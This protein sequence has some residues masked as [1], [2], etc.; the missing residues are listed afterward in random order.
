MSNLHHSQSSRP[1]PRLGRA[2]EVEHMEIAIPA[3]ALLE[4]QAQQHTHPRARIAAPQNIQYHYRL[5]LEVAIMTL[6]RGSST[7]PPATSSASCRTSNDGKAACRLSR[8]FTTLLERSFGRTCLL[9]TRACQTRWRTW[10]ELRTP[11]FRPRLLIPLSLLT[12]STRHTRSSQYIL[13]I[14]MVSIA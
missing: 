14:R 13:K 2:K 12:I 4:A 7:T 11:H 5:L 1:P 3:P 9:P 8:L 6:C 10:A